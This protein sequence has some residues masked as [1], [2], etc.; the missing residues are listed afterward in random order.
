[1]KEIYHIDLPQDK[2]NE[3]YYSRFLIIYFLTNTK[4]K[5]CRTFEEARK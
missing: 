3:V 5:M 4:H 1:L 2:T